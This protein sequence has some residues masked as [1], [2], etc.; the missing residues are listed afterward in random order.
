MPRSDRLY[1]PLKQPLTT[2]ITVSR[3]EEVMS[4][5]VLSV[6]F[7]VPPGTSSEKRKSDA[8][9]SPKAENVPPRVARLADIMPEEPGSPEMVR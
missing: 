2:V 4:V 1:P 6:T 5:H 8:A 9:G 3:K 7:C